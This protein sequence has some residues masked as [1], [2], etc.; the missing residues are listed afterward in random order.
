MKKFSFFLL[1]IFCLGCMLSQAQADYR[2][3]GL[4]Y[5]AN[6]NYTEAKV[7]FEAAKALLETKKVSRNSPEFIEIERL[8]SRADQC[9]T[10]RQRIATNLKNLKDD[11]ALRKAFSACMS[12]N[13]AMEIGQ[14]LHAS[15][16][17][18]KDDLM[19]V[20]GY[21][22][23]DKVSK[24]QLAECDELAIK[25]DTYKEGVNEIIAWNNADRLGSIHSYET[26]LREYPDGNYA[27]A[28]KGKIRDITDENNWKEITS[29][30]TLSAYKNYLQAFPNGIH[31]EEAALKAKEIGEE[32]EW[33]F[34]L[35]EN[36]TAGFKRYLQAY[37]DSRYRAEAENNLKL[38]QENDV[39]KDAL[40]KNTMA[41]YNNYLSK[42]S[43]G[44]YASLA[45]NRIDKLKEL[46]V[47]EKT[48]RENTIEA[49]K[50][51]LNTSKLKA[52]K[53]DAEQRIADIRHK[54]E[55]ARDEIRWAGIADATNSAVFAEY[56]REDGN[57]KGHVDE[58][59]GFER[60]YWARE[61]NI[62]MQNASE[63]LQAY[64]KAGHYVQLSS[65]DNER[66][67]AA[68]EMV[69]YRWFENHKTKENATSYLREYP[70]GKHA[71]IVSDFIARSKADEMTPDVTTAEYNTA[72]YFAKSVDAQNY[73]KEKYRQNVHEYKRIQR[74]LKTE[75]MHVLLGFEGT[76]LFP[77]AFDV[78]SYDG[79]ALLSLGGHSN[80]F[81]LEAGYY[82]GASSIVVRPKVNLVKRKYTGPTPL[83]YRKASD[84][85][86]FYLYVAPDFQYFLRDC[87][88][89][90]N[91]MIAS[92]PMENT[93]QDYND[94]YDDNVG[95]GGTPSSSF[96]YA[97][98]GTYNYGVRF[99]FG[100]RWLDFSFGYLFGDQ[101]MFTL[102]IA[103]YFGGK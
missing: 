67:K 57:Y 53:A 88:F 69:A 77:Q 11:E 3:K 34:A 86:L 70:S 68:A 36:T 97:A 80:R 43:K 16:K 18:A 58:A 98:E 87:Y 12:D 85:S 93:D 38:C 74:K 48:V 62:S 33:R 25:I 19:R 40:A 72:L 95:I 10:S 5:V 13:E 41:A 82:I 83:G 89:N 84:Y 51:Y 52:Y 2:A 64:D 9:A 39:W 65:K 15:L 55:V 75:P 44:Q 99:G 22:P 76:L 20:V 56:L 78:M 28:A 59:I 1:S 46:D 7:Q 14:R 21:F 49:Y 6:A 91:E 100:F 54:E 81:N 27:A 30:N 42:Y 101:K 96:L 35:E 66:K 26:F 29:I 63:I 73:V 103:A 90:Q 60:L 37:P 94:Y 32:E 31:A 23:E 50:Q 45:R 8:I 79:A 102:G 61:Q 47:W 24:S 17:N 92:E 71:A 4:G